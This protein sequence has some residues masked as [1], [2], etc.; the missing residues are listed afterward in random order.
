MS[1]EYNHDDPD[2]WDLYLPA[3][4]SPNWFPVITL[5]FKSF[6]RWLF[7]AVL[8]LFRH[9]QLRQ[10][11][12]HW[13]TSD[14]PGYES[15]E[16]DHLYYGT[17]RLED[18]KLIDCR[19]TPSD[20]TTLL[21]YPRALLN[22]SIWS[23]L[24]QD[25]IDDNEQV[26]HEDFFRAISGSRSC[27]SLEALRVDFTSRCWIIVPAPGM[28]RL[29][30]VKYLD[31]SAY[32]LQFKDESMERY[33]APDIDC[34][35]ER[36]LPPRIEV[37]KIDPYDAQS[38]EDVVRQI[39]PRKSEIV[40]RLR[41]IVL[42]NHYRDQKMAQELKEAVAVEEDKQ[43]YCRARSVVRDGFPLYTT[44]APMDELK[45]LCADKGVALVLLYEDSVRK[46]ILR[47]GAGPAL[48]EIPEQIR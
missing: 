39:L 34:P 46:E 20:L 40:P 19:F 47:E 18:L 31:V 26:N 4:I 15:I 13:A 3:K 6:S 24:D 30:N 7:E 11:E 41:K 33:P 35:L 48:W 9:T 45:S 28:D 37:L 14:C 32:H 1:L 38:D 2:F 8:S 21:E 25:V 43:N 16:Q 29:P 23:D 42:T 36:L 22:L 44:K 10:L 5:N 27:K 12:I 17:T